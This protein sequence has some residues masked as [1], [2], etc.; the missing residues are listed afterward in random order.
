MKPAVHIQFFIRR[1]SLNL[2]A[3]LLWALF[4]PLALPTFS[5]AQLNEADKKLARDLLQELIE[6]NTTDSVGNVSTASEAMAKRLREAGFAESDI[7]IG[8]PNDRKKNLVVRLRGTGSKKPVLLMG[9]LDVVEA[10]RE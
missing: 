2:R 4:L 10:H 1:Q 3:L 8:G 5:Q 6:I 9:H 7:F